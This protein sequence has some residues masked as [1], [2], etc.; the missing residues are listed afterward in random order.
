MAGSG[1]LPRKA[2]FPLAGDTDHPVRELGL[3]SNVFQSLTT[4]HRK[5][6]PFHH[7]L[8]LVQPNHQHGVHSLQESR[9]IQINSEAD[10]QEY[11]QLRH[12]RLSNQTYRQDAIPDRIKHSWRTCCKSEGASHWV[13]E[14]PAN[15]FSETLPMVQCMA[16]SSGW[17]RG[18]ESK[19]AVRG[20]PLC[21]EA[22][23]FLGWGFAR[24]GCQRSRGSPESILEFR[25]LFPDFCHRRAPLLRPLS[26][27]H[28][29]DGVRR[30]W[31]D[32]LFC[33]TE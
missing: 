11:D 8:S 26:L 31:R 1:D 23:R 7:S 9:P 29:H 32:P 12:V 25:D 24:H 14:Y 27:V 19:G 33:I 4:F 3:A 17:G 20:W 5:S 2:G 16:V 28:L 21:S 10:Q 13:A 30:V 15:A 22:A 6:S 18:G